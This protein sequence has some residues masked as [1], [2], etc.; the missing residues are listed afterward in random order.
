MLLIWIFYAFL[1]STVVSEIGKAGGVGSIIGNEVH[2][3]N[4]AAEGK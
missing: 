2:N 3:F 4:K 1:V